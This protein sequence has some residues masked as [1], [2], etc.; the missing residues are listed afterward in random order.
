MRSSQRAR[1]GREEVTTSPGPWVLTLAIVLVSVPFYVLGSLLRVRIMPG[2]PVSALAFVGPAVVA[3]WVAHRAGSMRAL[4]RR[5]FDIRQARP[6]AWYLAS[7]TLFPTVLAFEY[8]IMKVTHM[9]LP[10]PQI[11]WLRAPMLFALFFTTAAGEEIGWSVTLFEGFRL[12]YGSLGAAV[13]IGIVVAFWHVIPFSQAHPDAWW[14][15]GQCFFTVAFRVVIAWIYW[16][17]SRSLLAVIL[18]HASYNTG[19]QLFP[20]ESSA[21][22]PWICAA[23]TWALAVGL[24]AVT[25]ARSLNGHR[26][27]N[28]AS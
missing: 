26:P 6:L 15:L 20:N 17:S 7:A 9:P 2:L 23:L 18:C 28:S 22:D 1:T 12:R 24:T 14:I 27:A 5:V 19:W 25:G 4:I 21:Y 10:S 13:V 3:F 16:T 8:A 11:A